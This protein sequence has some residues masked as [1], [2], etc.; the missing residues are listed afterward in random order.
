MC[1][2]PPEQRLTAAFSTIF[3]SKRQHITAV[4]TPIRAHIGELLETMRNPMVDL[5]FIRISLRIGFTDTLCNHATVAFRMAGVLAVLALHTGRVLQKVAAKRASHDIVKLLRHEFVTE[6]LMDKFFTL[7]NGA[8]AVK[9][10]IE[11]SPVLGLLNKAER[12]LNLTRR[13]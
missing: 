4:A 7:A 1:L 13:L 6:H 2:N 10:D 3:L 8:L 11:W 5:F 9:A 12:Q